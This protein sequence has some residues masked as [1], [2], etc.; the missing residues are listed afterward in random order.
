MLFGLWPT[1]RLLDSPNVNFAS[2]ARSAEQVMNRLEKEIAEVE[3]EPSPASQ[4]FLRAWESY[5]SKEGLPRLT[6]G[7]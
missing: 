3:K 7:M 4:S 5:K 2:M 6:K 1:E